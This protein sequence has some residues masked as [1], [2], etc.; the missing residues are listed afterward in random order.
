MRKKDDTL[1]AA[2]LASAR[3]IADT[4]GI[5]AVNIRSIAQK[6]GVAAGTVYNYFSGKDEILLALT[7]D[8][9]VQALSEMQSGVVSDS[10][11][12][13]LE[14]M[15]LFLRERISRSAGKLMSSLGNIETSGQ[16]RMAAMQFA[17]EADILRRMG[18]DPGIRTDIWS[19]SFTPGQLAH[20][21]MSNMISLLK[22]DKP[23]F[24]FFL[25]AVRL[26]LYDTV[27]CESHSEATS[28]KGICNGLLYNRNPE[29]SV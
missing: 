8:E 23:D 9:W 10:F 11:C 14:E 12:G 4:E 29:K 13:Q 19:E 7:E 26:I 3:S 27:D 5:S 20:F 28:Q 24:R 18:Q 6:T 16:E 21:I 15:F 2:L 17:L 22:T 1:R 25:T